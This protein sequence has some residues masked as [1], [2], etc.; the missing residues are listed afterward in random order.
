MDESSGDMI[1]FE[2]GGRRASLPVG[3][4]LGISKAAVA[5]A[6]PFTDENIEGIVF[7]ESGPILQIDLTC[8]WGGIARTGRYSLLVQT[9]KGPVLLRVDAVS[10]GG[11]ARAQASPS[12]LDEIEGL[13]HRFAPADITACDQG[14]AKAQ[15]SEGIDLLIVEAS[16]MK[17]AFPTLAVL[18][19]DR[20]QGTVS[21]RGG[22]DGERLVTLAGNILAGYSLGRWL[23]AGEPTEEPWGLLF[24]CGARRIAVTVDAIHG[25]VKA[26]LH[27]LRS[28][29]LR[30][31]T[32]ICFP[33]PRFG[34]LEIIEPGTL[35]EPESDTVHQ[36]RYLPPLSS[37]PNDTDNTHQDLDKHQQFGTN[38]GVAVQAGAY[39]CVFPAATAH[40]IVRHVELTALSTRTPKAMPVL[41]LAALLGGDFRRGSETGHVLQLYRPGRRSTIVSA[42]HIAALSPDVVWYPLPI[43][44]PAFQEIFAAVGSNGDR[45]CFL[46][47]KSALKCKLKHL[48]SFFRP[49]SF[50]GW[51][52][53]S[54][55]DHEQHTSV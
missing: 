33:D 14:P 27:E 32:L 26:P 5:K 19:A 34:L 47:R 36:T 53:V 3:V 25:L 8:C 6:L 28:A 17:V 15:D 45:Y 1:Q 42:E 11:Y 12:V 29:T 18:Q 13:L 49:E 44:P 35:I 31:R 37:L 24:H 52:K 21:V 10:S 23:G 46:V 2:C 43:A 55:Q 50:M 7:V 16:G 4:V 48:A 54:S 38:A 22:E 41:N 9:S 20:H 40:L 39:S 30:H 51:A